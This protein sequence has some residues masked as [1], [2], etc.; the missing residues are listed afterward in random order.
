[1]SEDTLWLGTNQGLFTLSTHHQD[2][3][4]AFSNVSQVEGAVQTL[5]WR[6]AISDADERN[7]TLHSFVFKPS[8]K[9]HLQK[10]FACS[11]CHGS[12]WTGGY[13]TASVEH[14]FGVL[15]VGTNRKLYFYDGKEWWFEWVSGVPTALTFGPSGE[16]Y[17]A[18]HVSLTRVNI[19]YSFDRIGPLQGLPYN[20]LTSLHV[21]PY[22]PVTPPLTGPAPEPANMGTLWIGTARGYTLFN[23]KTSKFIGY[24]NGPRWLPEGS[25]LSIAGSGSTVVILT[26]EGLAVVHPEMWTLASKARHFQ[27]M[28][29]RHTRPPGLVSDCPI[30]SFTASTCSPSTTDSDGLWTSWVVAAEAFRYQVT[31]ETSARTNSWHLFSGLKFLVNVSTYDHLHVCPE[32]WYRPGYMSWYKPHCTNHHS[33]YR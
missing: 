1:M 29:Q 9:N 21:S 32:S 2:D 31:K 16:L 33:L 20:Q 6:S 30:T 10:N 4:L 22:V 3:C 28:L 24:F 11:N 25:V 13:W 8:A 14:G 18:D 27:A 26:E 19:D 17:I 5:A 12:Q 7:P 15:V 23:I